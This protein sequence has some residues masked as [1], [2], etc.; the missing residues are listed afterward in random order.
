[1]AAQGAN[2]AALVCAE[3]WP[4]VRRARAPGPVLELGAAIVAMPDREA[5]TAR[6]VCAAG[7]PAPR[8]SP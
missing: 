4:G 6:A 8:A 1:M 3:D 5:I 2:F 7:R